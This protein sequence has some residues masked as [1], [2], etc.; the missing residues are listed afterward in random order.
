[1]R[2]ILLATTALVFAS[3]AVAAERPYSWT[4]CYI[5]G[6]IGQGRTSTRFTEGDDTVVNGSQYFAPIGTPVRVGDTGGLGGVQA[7][8]DYQFA[9]N[10]LAGIG[11]D[12]SWAHIDGQTDDP[13][14]AGKNGAPL[15]LNSTTDR[16]GTVTGRVGYIWDRV[17]FFGRG[18][19]AWAHSKYSIQNL[20]FWGNPVSDWCRV[21]GVD[22]ACNPS[23]T[24]TRSGWTVGG[25]FE[26]AFADRWSVGIIYDHYD[27]GTRSVSLTDPNGRQGVP[28]TGPV[29]IKQTIDA[30]RLSL[31]YRFVPPGLR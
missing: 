1:M 5:G 4:G 31:N 6:H 3:Q 2:P 10:W 12:F 9:Q 14:F 18:G 29:E 16:M 24:Q 25:G 19:A 20:T 7:G 15:L 28:V 17:L 11:G 22:T 30:V 8:C 26:W 21:G 13:F 23:A 27:F